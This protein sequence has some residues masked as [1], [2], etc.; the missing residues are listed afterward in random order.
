MKI[1][2]FPIFLLLG[3]LGRAQT[4]KAPKNEVSFG[5]FTVGYFFDS[6]GV[7]MSEFEKARR[8]SL[9]FA[10]NLD[11]HFSIGMNYIGV[12][13]LHFK[14]SI[15][16]YYDNNT[17]IRRDFKYISV[18]AGYRISKWSMVAEVKSGINYRFSG[19]KAVH[20]FYFL[21]SG[22]YFESVGEYI[23]YKDVG[24]TFGLSLSHPILWKLYGEIDCEY[25]R[26]F[27]QEFDSH[28]SPTI[29][30]VKVR[31]DPNQL[32]LSYRIGIR[33]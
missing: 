27:P 1:L 13:Y 14:K 22:P 19:E 30:S 12:A 28:S 9:H 31:V 4:Q 3:S 25:A 18:Q 17:V 10:H 11:K 29:P 33:F 26:M 16:Q 7:R 23:R 24:I 15:P 8:V 2:I 5:Y 21:G 6:T 20:Y 32:L